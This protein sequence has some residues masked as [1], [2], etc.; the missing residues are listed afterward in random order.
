[1]KLLRIPGRTIRWTRR[2]AGESA[3]PW[4]YPGQS[5][6]HSMRVCWILESDSS[7]SGKEG[8]T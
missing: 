7:D 6:S 5:L 2:L 1:M 4:K 8:S 3:W